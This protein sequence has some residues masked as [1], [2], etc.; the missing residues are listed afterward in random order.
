MQFDNID[1]KAVGANIAK[2]RKV[3]NLTQMALANK[4]FVTN[5]AVSKW[6]TGEGLPDIISLKNLAKL[7]N[8]TI[9]ELLNPNLKN[10]QFEEANKNIEKLKNNIEIPGI[11]NYENNFKLEKT[12]NPAILKKENL[13]YLSNIVLSVIL[14][15]VFI[16][17]TLTNELGN[18]NIWNIFI[19]S[20]GT[21]FQ[22]II[23]ALFIT[24]IINIVANSVFIFIK[25][26]SV[27]NLPVNAILLTLLTVNHI[28]LANYY[29]V[30]P[31]HNLIYVLLFILVIINLFNLIIQ[32]KRRK[33]EKI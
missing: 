3:N 29:T 13:I 14:Y 22:F 20:P 6:E 10:D 5:K 31:L 25:K 18:I 19:K 28:T 23:L 21:V 30:P 7:F 27:I 26:L 24:L 2:L 12:K 8:I 33:N 4:L 15:F 17:L 32:L 1:V 11:N 16:N 9:E